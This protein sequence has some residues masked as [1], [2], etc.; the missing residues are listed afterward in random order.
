MRLLVTRPLPDAR[1][2]ADALAALGHTALLAPLLAVEFVPEVKLPLAGAQALIVTSRN[3]LRALSTHP[4]HDR[5]ISLPLVTVGEATAREAE[6]LGFSAVTAGGGTAPSLVGLIRAR[7]DPASGPLVHLAGET[8]AFDLKGALEA[9]GFAVRRPV[10]YRAVAAGTLPD[11]AIA[12]LAA[13][14]LDGVILMSPRTAAIFMALLHKHEALTEAR[15]LRCYCLS[16]SVA[17]AVAP[18]KALV[19]VPGAP[20]EEDIL[21]LISAD[22]ASS[23]G[24]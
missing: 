5:A 16:P 23:R 3:A 11:P 20:R 8:L 4:Q 6:R 14:S 17:E 22:A 2:Q 15:R 19:R 13:G 9:E 12:A 10:L 1:R 18:L 24:V 7:F 21:A